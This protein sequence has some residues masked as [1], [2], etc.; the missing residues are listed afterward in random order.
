MP[1]LEGNSVGLKNAP[2]GVCGFLARKFITLE[3]KHLSSKTLYPNVIDVK[4]V[5]VVMSIRTKRLP[6]C[7]PSANHQY[8]APEIEYVSSTAK[9]RNL[10]P[11]GSTNLKTP[12]MLL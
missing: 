12:T 4:I 8:F 9:R 7:H 3:P 5:P 2:L 10:S 1:R 11:D 6:L